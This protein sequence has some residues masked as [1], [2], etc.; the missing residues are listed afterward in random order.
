[1][2]EI[3]KVCVCFKKQVL[4]IKNVTNLRICFQNSEYLMRKLWEFAF[5]GGWNDADGKSKHLCFWKFSKMSKNG[6][7]GKCDKMWIF[8]L[9]K[10]VLLTKNL[11]ICVSIWYLRW[12]FPYPLSYPLLMVFYGIK[13]EINPKLVKINLNEWN[14]MVFFWN[15]NGVYEIRGIDV[16]WILDL[17]FEWNVC[18]FSGIDRSKYCWW[19]LWDFVMGCFV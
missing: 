16:V 4:L 17:Q 15:L 13:W 12:Q 18:W 1:M 2:V 9:K 10:W 5:R 11:S 7:D 3:Q 19:N 8:V 14:L 6:V